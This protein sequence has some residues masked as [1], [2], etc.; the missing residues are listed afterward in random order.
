MRFCRPVN[1]TMPTWFLAYPHGGFPRVRHV[2][3]PAD[4]VA[5][6]LQSSR[7]LCASLC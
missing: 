6:D 4:S 1:A 5:F 7:S 2:G 3:N